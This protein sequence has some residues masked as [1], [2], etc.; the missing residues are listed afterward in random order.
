MLNREGEPRLCWLADI[1]TWMETHLDEDRV[2][3]KLDQPLCFVLTVST[4]S[5]CSKVSVVTATVLKEKRFVLLL[6]WSS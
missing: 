3:D 1:Q 5:G 6:V 4:G 2:L